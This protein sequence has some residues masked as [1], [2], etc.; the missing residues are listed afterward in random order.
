MASNGWWLRETVLLVEHEEEFILE[1]SLAAGLRNRQ[2]KSTYT[3]GSLKKTASVNGAFLLAV[4][5]NR[6]YTGSSLK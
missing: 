4:Y 3:G 2:C 6:M 5:L 1:T